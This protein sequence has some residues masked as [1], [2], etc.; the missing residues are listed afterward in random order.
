MTEPCVERS[1]TPPSGGGRA[2]RG[3]GG[4]AR[5]GRRVRRI[6]RALA[7]VV[8]VAP[9]VIAGCKVKDPPP[10]KEKWTDDF[11]RDEIGGNYYKTGGEYTVTRGGLSARMGHNHPL[12]LR[13]QMPR[14]V[15]V[16][17][18]AW[19]T[20]PDGDIKVEIFGDGRSFDPDGGGYTSSGYVLIFG[21]WKNSKS[22][23]AKGNEHGSELKERTQPRV[24]PN[25]KYK[26][27]I[28]RK[29]TKLTWFIDDMTTPFLELEDPHP[30]AGRGHEY[31][32]FNN[33][34]T[35]V[36]FDD[37]VVTPL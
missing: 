6:A 24:V 28:I 32:A 14:D 16:D 23:I 1:E 36:W 22:M 3:F 26:W 20:S 2:K 35:D 5:E 33:W 30:L 8:A 7:V 10:I 11:S 27:R 31:F 21:G 25:Q 34:E 9:I 15:Q 12:W 37:L 13:K 19:S 4:T 17:V 29:G 18:T